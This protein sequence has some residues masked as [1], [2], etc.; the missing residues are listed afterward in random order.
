MD[1]GFVR[2]EMTRVQFDSAEG[3][4]WL[5]ASRGIVERG[6]DRPPEDCARATMRLV[7]AACPVLSGG[8]F[9]PDTDFERAL[10]EAR[11]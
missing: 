5:P 9:D 2:T 11:K 6:E 10:R 4:K 1:P 8:S 3:R 7:R